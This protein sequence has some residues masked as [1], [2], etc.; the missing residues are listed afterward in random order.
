MRPI[1]KCKNVAIFYVAAL[2]INL[3]LYASHEISFITSLIVVG[4]L[5]TIYFILIY[6]PLT[7]TDSSKN[8][9]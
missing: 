3:I 5:Y 7:Y 4:V 9:F 8:Y 2:V 6:S 1:M